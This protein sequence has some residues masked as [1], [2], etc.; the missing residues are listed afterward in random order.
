MPEFSVRLPHDANI[1]AVI[2]AAGGNPDINRWDGEIWH[3]DA[4]SQAALVEAL[5]TYDHNS[6]IIPMLRAE[7]LAALADRRWRSETGGMVFNGRRVST[8][9]E[10]QAQIDAAFNA[11]PAGNPKR[12]TIDFKFVDGWAALKPG[13]IKSLWD[14]K[15]D[16]VQ[17]RF[18]KE[19]EIC[20]KIQ[21]AKTVAELNAV[22]IET[23][24]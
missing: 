13:D 4:P 2:E 6:V 1:R 18:S 24:W 9:R 23:G 11:L 22:D 7:K 3:V 21:A 10:S 20:A 5:K 8:T 14:A 19:R 12:T 17:S 15:N 16:H